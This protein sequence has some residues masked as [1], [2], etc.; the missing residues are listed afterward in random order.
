MAIRRGLI[1]PAVLATLGVANPGF[2]A[3]ESVLIVNPPS[4]P[5]PVTGSV[6]GTVTG[7]AGWHQVRPS[8][9]RQVQV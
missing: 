5:V 9:S 6:T 2:A 1:A 4:K 3:D 7:T 8:G